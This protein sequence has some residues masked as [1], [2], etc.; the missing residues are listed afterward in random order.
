M[1]EVSALR[2]GEVFRDFC[3]A[4]QA[5]GIRVGLTAAGHQLAELVPLVSQ[6]LQFLSV[7]PGE[8]TWLAGL[9]QFAHTLG[10]QVYAQ[11]IYLASALE[12]LWECGFDGA[13]GPGIY[14]T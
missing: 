5:R 11:D 4:I 7:A 13:S 1:N 14:N 12:Q 3:L 2:Q 9:C 6:G 10:L 8:A